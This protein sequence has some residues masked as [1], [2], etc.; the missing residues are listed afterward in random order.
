MLHVKAIVLYYIPC[1]GEW[2]AMIGNVAL[3][4]F[5]VMIMA[6]APRLQR[7]SYM[8]ML[9]QMS[10]VEESRRGLE[11]G[12]M[13]FTWRLTVSQKPVQTFKQLGT[14]ALTR[15]NSSLTSTASPEQVLNTVM[16]WLGLMCVDRNAF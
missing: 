3:T 11:R 16:V 15:D 2:K 8:A 7:R 14:S 6:H 1:A 5:A 13:R 10:D 12:N 4:S 9:M